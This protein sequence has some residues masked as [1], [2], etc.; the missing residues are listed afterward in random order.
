LKLNFRILI[1][2]FNL[3]ECRPAQHSHLW[4]L[5]FHQV[6][7]SHWLRTERGEIVDLGR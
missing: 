4:K 3:Q 5:R 1:S 7:E 2:R 6:D